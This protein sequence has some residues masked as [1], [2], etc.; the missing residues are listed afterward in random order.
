M[1]GKGYDHPVINEA[2]ETAFHYESCTVRIQR[3]ADTNAQLRAEN[4]RLRREIMATRDR[5]AD[6]LEHIPEELHFARITLYTE[7]E[8]MLAFCNH[9]LEGQN[10]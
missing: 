8:H 5:V 10:A 6:E 2:A 4:E 3:L 9:L 7:R 1:S